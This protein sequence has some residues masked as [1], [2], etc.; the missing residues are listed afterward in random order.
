MS[1]PSNP[2][3]TRASAQT[4]GNWYPQ[5]NGLQLPTALTS[6]ITQTLQLVYANR[7]QTT[8]N[9]NSIDHMVQYGTMQQR[10]DAAPTALPEGS[11]WFVTDFPNAVYQ[12]RVDPKMNQ[13]AWFYASGVVWQVNS[14]WIAAVNWQLGPND[15]GYMIVTGGFLQVWNGT[16]YDC[17]L[18]GPC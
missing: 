7:D 1:T 16:G 10:L 6:S 15:Q 13:L 12:V 17:K 5:L 18:K 11:L 8:Q 4:P 9:S 3:A 14:A 2:L